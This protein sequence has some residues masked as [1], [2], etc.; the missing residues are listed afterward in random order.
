ML[1]LYYL[2]ERKTPA[3]LKQLIPQRWRIWLGYQL[4]V[5]RGRALSDGDLRHPLQLPAGETEQTLFDYLAQFRVEGQ[6]EN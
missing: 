2:L 1:N 5:V 3:F 4:K 6:E